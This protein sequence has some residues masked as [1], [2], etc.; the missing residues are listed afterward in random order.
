MAVRLPSTSDATASTI[1]MRCQ[2]PASGSRPSTRMRNVTAN[3][4]SFGAEPISIVTGVG[5]PW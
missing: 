2:S 1:S 4:A 5:A 3:T